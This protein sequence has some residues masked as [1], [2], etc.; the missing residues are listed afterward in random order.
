MP[1]HNCPC[2]GNDLPNHYRVCPHDGTML[3]GAHLQSD[4]VI[5]TILAGAYHITAPIS[6]GAMG[7]LYE[8]VHTRLE[9][10]FAIKVMHSQFA[11]NP[12]A[13]AR[14]ER[15][16]RVTGRI[17]SDHVVDVIDVMRVPD[18]RPCMVAELLEGED[19]HC[20]MERLGRV[21][22][23]TALEITEQIGLGL[24]A[25]HAHGTIHRDLK[26]SNI[27][28][29]ASADGSETVKLLDFGVAKCLSSE[30]ITHG[31]AIVG[32]PAYMAPEQAVA[33]AR[34]DVR[35]DVY[36]VGAVLYRM[37]TGKAPHDSSDST[38]ALA[39]L[40][41]EEPQRP[42]AL[43]PD[44]PA[45]VEALVQLCLSRNP[46]D[47][48]QDALAVV[49]A[50]R[51]LLRA[52]GKT[53]ERGAHA[54]PRRPQ[55]MPDIDRREASGPTTWVVPVGRMEGVLSRADRL[56]WARPL[57]IAAVIG[58]AVAMGSFT[59]AV[60]RTALPPDGGR[61]DGITAVLTHLLA[62]L[63]AALASYGLAITMR[64]H[65][66]S[67]PALFRAARRAARAQLAGVACLGGCALIAAATD[68]A[69]LSPSGIV[70]L[71]AAALAAVT[72]YGLEGRNRRRPA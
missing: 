18:G 14:F 39:R 61:G 29:A 36:G 4:P 68:V 45:D 11:K 59:L 28:L 43:R 58:A 66:Q 52:H 63:T 65:W 7:R 32:T 19:L 46:A 57:S 49:A 10:R 67:L 3:S 69:W 70:A 24:A 60:T 64:R 31:D 27:F 38:I 40:L 6:A 26:P 15:E 62:A 71:V 9:R 72:S 8:A 12:A 21:D 53:V 25:A 22:V 37:L 55:R 34:V 33:A 16:A 20:R 13:V 50:V 41:S 30:D 5:G 56:R 1:S 47:R 54:G 17:C 48:P 44:L 2:C 51:G 42:R 35:A 23:L